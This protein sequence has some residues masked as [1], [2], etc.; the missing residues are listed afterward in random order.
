MLLH[1]YEFDL[2]T[3]R[4]MD[5]HKRNMK[6]LEAKLRSTAPGRIVIFITTHSDENR[7]DFFAGKD[8]QG[9]RFS[10]EVSQVRSILSAIVPELIIF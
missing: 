4:K 5:N 8:A 6:S 2:G 3:T 1:D 10:V 7:G 9:R